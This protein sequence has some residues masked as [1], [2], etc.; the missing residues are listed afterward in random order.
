MNG[1]LIGWR[2][3]AVMLRAGFML[4]L[5]AAAWQDLK[6]RRIKI[7][8]FVIFGGAGAAL[9][10]IQIGLELG[11]ICRRTD[12]ACVGELIWAHL[13]DTGLAVALGGGLLL[14]SAVTRGAVG[15]GDGWF[16]AVSGLYLGAVKN[17]LLLAGGLAGCFILCVILMIRGIAK[18]RSVRAMRLP[19][20]PFLIPAG[21]GVMFL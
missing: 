11:M 3:V 6:E 20:L 5:A 15:R 10:C 8:I 14:L 21:I 13:S 19:F 16:F 9:R 4:F 18:G 1:L 7:C 17:W 2:T 12:L